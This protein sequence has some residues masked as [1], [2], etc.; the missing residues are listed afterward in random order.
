MHARRGGTALLQGRCHRGNVRGSGG[1]QRGEAVTACW[2]GLSGTSPPVRRSMHAAA[3]HRRRWTRASPGFNIS[4]TPPSVLA[5]RAAML[6][7]GKCPFALETHTEVSWEKVP[8]CAC[9][10]GHVSATSAS[11]LHVQMFVCSVSKMALILSLPG[12]AR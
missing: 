3:C 10:R 8:P 11:T 1:Q 6:P 12:L 9:G 7:C 2:Q 4:H 5:V